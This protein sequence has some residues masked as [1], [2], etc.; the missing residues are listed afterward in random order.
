MNKHLYRLKNIPNL[1]RGISPLS[2]KLA[3][4]AE[5]YAT[6]IRAGGKREDLGLIGN[7]V[8]TTVGVGYIVDAFQ[9][10]VELETM[11]YHGMGTG[12]VAENVSD[13]ALGIEVETRG[14][15]TTE[16][17]ATG[18]IYKSIGTCTA[19]VARVI[20]E[21]GLFSAATVGVLLDRTVFAA[22]NL[23]NGDA[24]QFTYQLTLTA[25]S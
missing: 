14:T 11:K 15:G 25:G 24:V 2:N 22:I 4:H 19:T 8:V 1:L 12:A 13:T 6:V 20:T 18:N 21:H 9:N 10:I 23:A 3:A 5:L 17:G 16:E 7:R